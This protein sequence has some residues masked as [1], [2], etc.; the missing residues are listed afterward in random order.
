MKYRLKSLGL[1]KPDRRVL[2]A[3]EYKDPENQI[4]VI[5]RTNLLINCQS[6]IEYIFVHSQAFLIASRFSAGVLTVTSQPPD[7]INLRPASC[8]TRLWEQALT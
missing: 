7:N 8:L 4:S 5:P 1:K 3:C 6:S 2:S